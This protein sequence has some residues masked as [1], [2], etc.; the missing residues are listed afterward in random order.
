ELNGPSLAQQ[1]FTRIKISR[2]SINVSF[3]NISNEIPGMFELFQNYPNPFNPS[4]TIMFAIS[5]QSNVTLKIF[6]INGREIV[7][8]VNNE[9]VSIG[10]K[11]IN[12]D[13][14]GLS[15]GIYLYT[16]KA[17]DFNAMKKMLLIK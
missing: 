15:S 4:T 2:D 5:E 14:S 3:K 7:I 6:D 10:I 8:L 16:I 11:E 17:N 1:M 9:T 12:F 13:A